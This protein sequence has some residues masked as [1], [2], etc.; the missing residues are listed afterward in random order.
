MTTPFTPGSRTTSRELTATTQDIYGTLRRRMLEYV[1]AN[2]D[3]AADILGGID[4]ARLYVIRAPDPSSPI[5]PYGIMNLKNQ[6][7]DTGRIGRMTA[8]LEVQ[9]YGRPFDTLPDVQYAADVLVAATTA[10]VSITDGLTFSR[11]WQRDEFPMPTA[12]ADSETCTIRLLFPLVI[13]PKMLTSLAV[14]SPS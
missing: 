2:G 5:F 10:F 7:S 3:S 6:R 14:N 1:N 12:P 11:Q 13:W 9:L 8:D 4:Q